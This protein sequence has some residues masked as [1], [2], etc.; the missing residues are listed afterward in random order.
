MKK[1]FGSLIFV[2]IALSLLSSTVTA[3]SNNILF[4]GK[5]LGKI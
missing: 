5:D 4:Y 2:I 3:E 1:I